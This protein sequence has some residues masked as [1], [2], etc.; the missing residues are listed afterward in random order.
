MKSE[1]TLVQLFRL[2]QAKETFITTY[3]EFLAERMLGG[4]SR[5]G[6]A[7]ER[8]LAVLFKQECGDN[9]NS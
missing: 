5:G 6:T 3:V 1:K 7:K 8:Q 2:L 4:L 9:F